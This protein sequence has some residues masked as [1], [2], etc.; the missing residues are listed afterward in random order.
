MNDF[1]G[2]FSGAPLHPSELAAAFSY[3]YIKDTIWLFVQTADFLSRPLD[4]AS[5]NYVCG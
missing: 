3:I 1:A 2:F 5:F 4:E